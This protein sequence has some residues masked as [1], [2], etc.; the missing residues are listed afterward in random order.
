MV[1]NKDDG[2]LAIQQP[3]LAERF[4]VKHLPRL[5]DEWIQLQVVVEFSDLGVDAAGAIVAGS[6][7]EFPPVFHHTPSSHPSD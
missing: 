4:Q 6:T 1:V 7:A 5:G 3:P 2:L